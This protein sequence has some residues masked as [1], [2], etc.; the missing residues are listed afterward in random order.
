MMAAALTA[1]IMAQPAAER[2]GYALELLAFYLDPAPD[3][4]AAIA[5]RGLRLTPQ[6][7]RIL[8][9]LDRRRGV[10]VT[11]HALH[12]AAMGDRAPAD[13]SDPSTVYARLAAIRHQLARA[14]VPVTLRSLR[15]LGYRLEVPAGFSWGIGHA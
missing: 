5:D 4:V 10:L 9:A 11:R 14:G 8:H 15:G 12:A 3:F 6:E 2:L 13:W 1:E 7:V